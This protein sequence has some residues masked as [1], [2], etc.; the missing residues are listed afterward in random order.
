M[1]DFLSKGLSIKIRKQALKEF[2]GYI[3]G[4]RSKDIVAINDKLDALYANENF[5]ASISPDIERDLSAV[6]F[7]MSLGGYF[8]RD[9]R[10]N[11]PPL[12]KEN[13]GK[14][15][16]HHD[17]FNLAEGDTSIEL[18]DRAIQ[19]SGTDILQNLS[20][21]YKFYSIPNTP[22]ISSVIQG[23][24]VDYQKI[25]KSVTDKDNKV[26]TTYGHGMSVKNSPVHAHI[27]TSAGSIPNRYT[28]PS[29]GAVIFNDAKFGLNSRSADEISVFYNAIP[30]IEFS[31]CAPFL[32][33]NIFYGSG[34]SIKDS[35]SL[36][37]SLR[38]LKKIEN[39]KIVPDE[40]IG[41]A[42]ATNDKYNQ[43]INQTAL[44][45]QE[46]IDAGLNPSISSAGMELFTS[47]QTLSNANINNANIGTYPNIIEPISSL[48]SIQSF[49]VSITGMGV[50][51]YTSKKASLILKLSD[52]SR[53]RD[54]SPLIT[55]EQFGQT[56]IE[57]E[58]G[59]SHPD[60]GVQSN[61][62]YGQ[63][64]N[65]MRDVGIYN[66]V[67]SNLSFE[68]NTVNIN[69]TLAMSA[70]EDSLNVSV[71]C[72]NVVQSSIFKPQIESLA[73]AYIAQKESEGL[74]NTKI[75]DI[76]KKQRISLN[77]SL[78][79]RGVIDRSVFLN[80]MN[81]A[82]INGQS[83]PNEFKRLLKE[84]FKIIV[85]EDEEIPENNNENNINLIRNIGSKLQ[86]IINTKNYDPYLELGF[87]ETSGAVQNM[88]VDSSIVD[89]TQGS[90]DANNVVSLGKILMSFVGYTFSSIGRYDEVQMFFYPLNK[91]S[92]G[93]HIYNTA[94]FPIIVPD[95]EKVVTDY[96]FSNP[97]LTVAKFL[98]LMDKNF[99][100]KKNYIFYGLSVD[101]DKLKVAKSIDFS[102][103]N[104][105]TILDSLPAELKT[106]YDN[107]SNFSDKTDKEKLKEAF[108]NKKAL[109][110]ALT[111]NK[112]SDIPSY[113][114]KN[115]S[116]VTV[117][118]FFEKKN[119][120]F[121]KTISLAGYKFVDGDLATLQQS[122]PSKD[123]DVYKSI[124]NTLLQISNEVQ[125]GIQKEFN[126]ARKKYVS[127][128]QS[129][130][131]K[132]LETIYKSG[133]RNYNYSEPKFVPPCLK[134]YYE[135]VPAIRPDDLSLEDASEYNSKS[136]L[137]IHV[138]D[139]RDTPYDDE[140]LLQ[141]LR[142]EGIINDNPDLSE[143]QK[144]V[145]NLNAQDI[146]DVIMQTTPHIIYGNANSPISSFN[147]SST[148]SGNVGNTLLLNAIQNKSSPQAGHGTVADLEDVI[149]IPSTCNLS[150]LGMPLLQAGSQCYVD[151]STGTS[152]DN[153]YIITGISHSLSPGSFKSQ[154][155][156]TFIAQS[157]IDTIKGKIRKLIR[158]E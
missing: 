99:I 34:N 89:A 31:R 75:R 27:N 24:S 47:P 132:K 133:N 22:T 3:G 50:G 30:T 33:L 126:D 61:N 36:L 60:G 134:I 112:L 118:D 1:K 73:N 128:I 91:D 2:S 64:L 4:V 81:A 136:I 104:D 120:S 79:N 137:R 107:V 6:L 123:I 83:N 121:N 18:L 84:N 152:V 96:L 46:F 106:S 70:Y 157:G 141:N 17:Y 26:K 65:S 20:F 150:S 114:P 28:E 35:M 14:I 97:N 71:A 67:S 131:T 124:V 10:K 110:D 16:I 156:L 142:T 154:A 52:R 125:K 41:Y 39:G 62:P 151:M 37:T 102:E 66:V 54:I 44:N 78:S 32:S 85:D 42:N 155:N 147:M 129:D 45:Q 21:N 117:G 23:L 12:D 77:E 82:G 116:L 5:K 101:L 115:S 86:G 25:S 11:L 29:L 13:R 38:F 56:R 109:S 76:R 95:F 58:Y 55:P 100:G 93:G 80:I 108:N 59:W 88:I 148:T 140:L 74:K 87:D 119:L 153:L 68:G 53:L 43:S 49:E 48:L 103:N 113:N 122:T 15:F 127:E 40:N 138:Y 19:K 139:E 51:L 111:K 94:N 7:G 149:L 158:D 144:N 98:N 130:I 135:D 146:K 9:M 63:F 72:G 143:L 8:F 92:A 57:I 145:E 90:S 69:L 105:K